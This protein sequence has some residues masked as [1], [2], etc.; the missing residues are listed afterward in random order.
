M[1]EIH[2]SR[3]VAHIVDAPDTSR[4]STNEREPL[5]TFHGSFTLPVERQPDGTVAALCT[6][7]AQP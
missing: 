5:R 3:G 1:R 4:A 7:E 2:Y 6:R